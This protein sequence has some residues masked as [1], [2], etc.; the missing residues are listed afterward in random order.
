M[1]NIVKFQITQQANTPINPA[2]TV[3]GIQVQKQLG[4]ADV[5][6]ISILLHMLNM[7]QTQ[8]EFTYGSEVHVAL[9][10]DNQGLLNVFS[11]TVQEMRVQAERQTGATLHITAVATNTYQPPSNYGDASFV[12]T[13][14]DNIYNLN[15]SST[16]P[17]QI[18]GTLNVQG[19]AHINIGQL[20][21]VQNTQAFADGLWPVNGLT[22]QVADGNW[23]TEVSFG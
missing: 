13:Y 15:L 5:A 11:G 10:Y 20:V 19:N 22:H 9:G 12:F 4:K 6:T 8:H 16:Q 3:L 14:G 2:I 17:N 7:N 18:Q 1:S 21:Q 23:L